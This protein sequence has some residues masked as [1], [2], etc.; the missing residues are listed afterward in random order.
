MPLALTELPQGIWIANIFGPRPP[1]TVGNRAV[2]VR[3]ASAEG[4]E[5]RVC[6]RLYLIPSSRSIV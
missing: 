6:P 5:G 4:V 1:G 2:K 3:F